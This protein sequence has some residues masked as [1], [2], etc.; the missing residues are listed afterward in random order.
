MC[1]FDA[2]KWTGEAYALDYDMPPYGEPLWLATILPEIR[3]GPVVSPGVYIGEDGSASGHHTAVFI[4]GR[5]GMSGSPV[6]YRGRVVGVLVTGL[7]NW[8]EFQWTGIL[9]LRAFRA[10]IEEALL[11]ARGK[12]ALAR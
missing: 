5:P 6:L 2:A 9:P 7:T 10:E 3:R 12:G 11:A 8:R 4:G 1:A